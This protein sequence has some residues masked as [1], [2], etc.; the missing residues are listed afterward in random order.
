M[1]LAVAELSGKAKHMGVGAGLFGAAGVVAWFGVG[2]AVA[3]AVAALALVLPVWAS[4]LIVAAV[5]FAVAAVAGF[6][7][8]GQV[9]QATPVIPERATDSVQQDLAA[10]KGVRHDEHHS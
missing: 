4:A 6:L 7:G 9:Q 8:K 1:Q 2:T 3:G 5:L 10:V